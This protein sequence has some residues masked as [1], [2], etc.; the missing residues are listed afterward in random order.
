MAKVRQEHEPVYVS[1]VL[2]VKTQMRDGQVHY[3]KLA[4]KTY[5]P[6]TS[7]EVEMWPHSVIW[8]PEDG[9]D[10]PEQ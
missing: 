3:F 10:L 5:V 4:G 8:N 9:R 7:Q 1:P 2:Y 6:T